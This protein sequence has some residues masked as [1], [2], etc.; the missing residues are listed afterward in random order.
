SQDMTA[1]RLPPSPPEQSRQH[2]SGQDM[3]APSK[4]ASATRNSFLFLFFPIPALSLHS[5]HSSMW[6]QAFSSLHNYTPCCTTNANHTL[7]CPTPWPAKI[8]ACLLAC[9]RWLV[10]W[11]CCA[12]QRTRTRMHACTHLRRTL[13]ANQACLSSYQFQLQ[14]QLKQK[15]GAF[16]EARCLM[17]GQEGGVRWPCRIARCPC[18]MRWVAGVLVLEFCSF[19]CFSFVTLG[20]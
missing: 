9:L 19:R 14:L 5:L 13:A 16:L 15:I 11:R 3:F 1:A 2:G 20:G 17:V 4:L 10:G 18:E 8:F 12:T 7:S 6:L